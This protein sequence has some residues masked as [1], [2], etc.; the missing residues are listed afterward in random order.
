M[1]HP[2]NGP[3]G[4]QMAKYR[5]QEEPEDTLTYAEEIQ[6][7]QV[8]SAP[9]A[10]DNDEASFKKRYGDLRRHTQQLI[11]QK[12]QEISAVKQQLDTA[13]KGQIKF[14]KTDDEIDQWSRKYPDVALIVDTIARKRANKAMEEGDKRL[15][16]LKQL[17]TKLTRKDAEQQLVQ[18]HPD[19]NVIRQDAAFHDWVALQPQNIQ[20]SLYKNNTDAR[21]AARAIDL[22]KSD[23]GKRKTTTKKSAAHAVGRTSSFTRASNGK[24][25]FSESQVSKMS[26][27]DF[28]KH[29]EAIGDAMRSGNFNYDLSG[30][31]R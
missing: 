6:Q 15:A 10:T 13:A 29:E 8:Q 5:R 7:E 1:G 9:E 17:E 2:F 23:T 21:A 14:P 28:E 30:G 22:Y 27:N 16:G 24:M 20:D 3:H 19:F 31:V 4:N 11:Q 18:V 26:D 25:K 12:D